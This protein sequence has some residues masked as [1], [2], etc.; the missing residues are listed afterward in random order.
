MNCIPLKFKSEGLTHSTSQ[1]VTIFGD[2]V[3][4]AVKV[5]NT[6]EPQSSR[7]GVLINRGRGTRGVCAEKRP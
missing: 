7:T 6:G 4:K 2:R 5:G 1:N 3:L